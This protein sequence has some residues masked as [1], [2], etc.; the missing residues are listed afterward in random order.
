MN[1]SLKISV[2]ICAQTL[3]EVTTAPVKM[4]MLCR[5]MEFLV[6]V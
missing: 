6:K 5:R 2:I 3:L 4:A 1:A